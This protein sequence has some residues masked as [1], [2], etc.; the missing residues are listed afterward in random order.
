MRPVDQEA[1]WFRTRPIPNVMT[2]V[3]RENESCFLAGAVAGLATK[4]RKVGFV[5]GMQIPIIRRF[6][7][8]F[9]AGL[10]VIDPELALLAKRVYTG[11]FDDSASGK[12]T[13]LDLYNQ[14]VDVVFHAAGAGGIGVIQ[15][16]KEQN[17]FAIGCDS[18][19]AHLAP[20]N[21]I[22]STL[23]HVDYAVYRAIKSVVD[24]KFQP[25]DSFLGLRDGGVG[26]AP[27]TIDFPSKDAAIAKVEK[28]H[29]AVIAGQIKVPAAIDEL[30]SWTPPK[31]E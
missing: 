17:K 19:Q 6:E 22:T 29:K 21:V 16:A 13:A 15:A 7:A 14:G 31:V 28:L 8:G 20:A 1:F 10:K 3:F 26:L 23:K 9:V 30:D 11:N 18:D 25:G 12:R 5:G 2:A 27:I 4:S 24:N